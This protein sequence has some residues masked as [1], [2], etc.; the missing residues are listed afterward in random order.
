MATSF[1]AFSRSIARQNQLKGG[2]VVATIQS[3]SPRQRRR[4]RWSRRPR[5]VGDR[6]VLHKLLE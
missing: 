3:I 4:R 6:N 1:S 2:V 5:A